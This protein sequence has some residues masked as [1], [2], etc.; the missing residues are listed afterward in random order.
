M[1]ASSDEIAPR[2]LVQKAFE[3]S[4]PSRLGERP[5]GRAESSGD[6]GLF[7]VGHKAS[8]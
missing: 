2:A 4:R 1:S 6:G 8:Q 7:T 5:V 3:K